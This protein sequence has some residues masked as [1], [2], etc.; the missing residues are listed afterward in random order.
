MSAVPDASIV[1][2][3]NELRATALVG[4]A[5]RTAPVSRSVAGVAPS[6]EDRDPEAVVLDA[7][8]IAGVARA[9]GVVASSRATS[10]A[11]A[12]DDPDPV[13]PPVAVQ[14]LELL[15]GQSPAAGAHRD[16]LLA[17]W[18]ETCAAADHRVPPSMLVRVFDHAGPASSLRDA[19]R[20]VIGARG[21]W[22]AAHHPDW[23]WAIGDAVD[24]TTSP[25]D[26]SHLPSAER[27]NVVRVR[28]GTDP[29]AARALVESTWTSDAATARAAHLGA[30][31]EGLGPDD[32]ALLERALD[33]RAKSVRE[34][35]AGLLD[36]LP[37]SA[38]ARRMTDRL[39]PLV[40]VAGRLRGRA[41]SVELPDDPDDAGVRDGLGTAAASRSKRAWWLERIITGTPLS[42]WTDLTG[43]DPASIDRRIDDQDVRRGL[44]AAALAQRDPAWA[45][46]L[47]ERTRDPRLL[48]V[49]APAARDALVA[50]AL[51]VRSGHPDVAGLLATVPPPWSAALSTAAID[52]ARESAYPA[53][54]LQHAGALLAEG[55]DDAGV[56][57][58]DIWLAELKLQESPPVQP[59]A[60][61]RAVLQH[62]SLHRSI[63]EAFP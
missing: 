60:A 13:A 47:F 53:A 49:A 59:S 35:A 9:A 29:A 16:Q 48:A 27:V 4:T 37:S 24:A 57:R 3:W 8:A 45:A 58:L 42:F 62:R 39:A 34:V 46:A 19:T 22:L 38:R 61:I 15:L 56:H 17:H 6:S 43:D 52:A 63:I 44:V 23:G 30:L 14:L 26:W 21:R 40:S 51:K 12:P 10:L 31:V 28:R 54:V 36:G 1:G 11:P 55:L 2:W 18:Y 25:D 32:E 41:I 5:R 20:R 50:S 33:D 7:V